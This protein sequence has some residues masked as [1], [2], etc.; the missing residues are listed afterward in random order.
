M[1]I[2]PYEIW[3]KVDLVAYRLDLPLELSKIHNLFHVL[4][5]RRYRSKLNHVVQIEELKIEPNL[6]YE[7]EPVSILAREVKE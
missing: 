5:L 3:D 7:E 6:S 4:M 1:F 2:G